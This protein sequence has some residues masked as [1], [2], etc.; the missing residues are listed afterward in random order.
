MS[1]K[2]DAKTME[3]P[4]PALDERAQAVLRG[5]IER[6]IREG[7]PVGS[8]VLSR[9]LTLGLSPAS[10]RNVMADLEDLG[11]ISSP[12][13]SAGRMPTRHGYRVFVD[14]LLKVEP[15]GPPELK[16]L[17]A[18]LAPGEEG[19]VRLAGETSRMV[20]K[21]TRMAGLVT[22]PR[23]N[24]AA[25]RH[26]EFL[27]LSD[28]RVLAVLVLDGREVQNRVLELEEDYSP[29]ILEATANYLN[30]QFAGR[31]LAEVRGRL[32]SGMRDD[33]RSMNSLTQT[34]LA[35]GERMF[36]FSNEL[37]ADYVL[38]GETNL[39]SF[40]DLSDLERLKALFEAFERKREILELLDRALAAPGVQIFIGE[41]SG[42]AV[43]GD[44]SVVVSSYGEADRPLG[45]VGVI[46]PTRMAYQKVIPVVD[47]TARL[48]GAALNADG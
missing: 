24:R 29:Q 41:E 11:L 40:A 33:M 47:V 26:I 14:S 30:E 13:V 42:Y 32:L 20:A 21:I 31:T 25:W 36:D 46:G 17:H 35:M 38:S 23:R 48:L 18:S 28:H 2:V 5:L 39:M 7:Q 45:V 22:V 16:H 8:R 37:E 4:V 1:N 15:L 19:A 44:L 9:D 6:Y 12:H 43:L 10:I 3:E 34:A 27:R